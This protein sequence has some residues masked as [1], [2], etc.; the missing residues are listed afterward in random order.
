MAHY[1]TM[2]KY[3][4]LD[5]IASFSRFVKNNTL[6]QA[7][8]YYEKAKAE[9]LEKQNSTDSEGINAL[10]WIIPTT[11]AVILLGGAVAFIALRKKKTKS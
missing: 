6:E 8:A 1:E 7:K 3:G 9:R 5:G 10:V 4:H 2:K 11:A